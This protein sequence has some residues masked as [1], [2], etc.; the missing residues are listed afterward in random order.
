[1]DMIDELNELIG[2]NG[3]MLIPGENDNNNFFGDNS[4]ISRII[5]QTEPGIEEENIT[6]QQ[7]LFNPETIPVNPPPA[8]AANA[9]AISQAIEG[10]TE[11]VQEQLQQPANEAAATT[12]PE[13]LNSTA[14]TNLPLETERL[15]KPRLVNN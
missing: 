1:M 3:S 14:I 2:S 12:T 11:R 7:Q 13:F 15:L 6:E 10:L 8:A 9:D 5:A 4:A